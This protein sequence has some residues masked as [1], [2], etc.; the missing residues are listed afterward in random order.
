MNP[1]QFT[2]SHNGDFFAALGADQK[3][4]LYPIAGGD[5]HP[6]P[7]VEIGERPVGFT[8][9]DRSLFVYRYAEMPARVFKLDL[10]TGKRSLWKQLLPP[11]PAGVDHI[12]GII[13]SADEKSYVYSYYPNLSDLYLVE[14]AK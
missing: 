13:I 1:T 3:M 5:P 11:D 9:D 14:G 7:G 6:V 8:T 10:A 12:G 4:Y 2:L